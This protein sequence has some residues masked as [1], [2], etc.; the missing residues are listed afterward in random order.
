M[1]L[2]MV[3][4]AMA[5]AQ[6]TVLLPDT[7]QTTTLTANVSEQARVTVPAGVTFNVTDLAA[8]TAASAASVSI[9]NIAL[10]SATKQLKVSLQA[11]AASFTPPV[12]GA[13][14]WSAGDVS[15]NAAAW[16]SAT[17]SAGTLSNSSYNAVATCDA[18]AGSCNSTALVFTL[19]AKGT[20]KRSGN[21]TLVVTWKIESIGS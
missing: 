3:S 9:S 15:W 12:G 14:T 10:A 11:N 5:T 19:A 16:T 6:T 7:S 17:G 8:S 13:T 20:V 1:S 2:L 18:D 4:S 21:H